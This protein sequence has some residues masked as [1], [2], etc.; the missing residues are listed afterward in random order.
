MPFLLGLDLSALS[1]SLALCAGLLL[2]VSG[3]GLDKPLNRSFVL[4]AG[5]ETGFV[6]C[7][8]LLRLALHFSV[9]NPQALLELVAMFFA[10]S[11]AAL[12]LF[13]IRFSGQEGW[14]PLGALAAA[15]VALLALLPA[16]L[17]GRLVEQPLLSPDGLLFYRITEPGF[18]TMLVP[19]ALL[20]AASLLSVSSVGRR[21]GWSIALSAGLQFGGF[22][23]G[24][25]I[26]PHLPVMALTNV[27]SVALLGWG[28]TRLQ[29]FNPL[30]DL[31]VSLRERAHRQE[32][33]AEI[34]RRTTTLLP[35]DELLNQAAALVRQSFDYLT[36]AVFL[37]EGADLV[38]K[39]STH[40]AARAHI[41]TFRLAVGRE[42]LCGWVASE[43]RPL[44]VGDVRRDSRY[45]GLLDST[46]TRS[47]LSVPIM[48][49]GRVIGVLDAQSRS[50]GAFGEPDMLTLQTIADQISSSIENARLYEETRRRAERLALVNRI[51]AASGAVLD[52]DDLLETVYR[53][54]TPIFE[55][56]AFFIAL[57]EETSGMLEFR[58]MVDEGRREPPVRE[59]VG[60]GLTAQVVESR[61]PVL[62]ND[63]AGEGQSLRLWGSGRVPA[64]W[65]GAPM[66]VGDRLVGVLSVQS[67]RA[68]RY[69][70][71]DLLLAATIAEQ[72]GVA[73]ENARLYQKVT[74]ELE[75]RLRT[76]KGLRESE[77][78]FRNLAEESPNMILIYADQRILYANR[79]C[80]VSMG[81][82]RET[83]YAPTFDLISL[84]APG[85]ET[86]AQRAARPEADARDAP[87]FEMVLLAREGRRVDALVTT[88][89][90]GF[91]GAP[92]TLTI[93]T[94]ITARKRAERLL[95]SLNAATLAMEQA[96]TPTEIFPS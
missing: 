71:E 4:F 94:D 13:C 41:G 75:V 81:Y 55:A 46:Q 12:L 30:H 20:L 84:V 17:R 80:E 23:A 83:L 96:L 45:V 58:L 14:W 11:A 36:V 43:G 64:S 54:V 31:T 56:D 44:V 42:G 47:E 93:V 92:A 8:V 35:L 38:L 95:Q 91:Q 50:R 7:S 39:A 26:Q 70:A 25:L 65:I 89:L 16:L 61:A 3:A 87:P 88:R 72:V 67:Y 86:L 66:L 18:L 90:I 9:G 49:S 53:E 48:R 74:R 15:T 82:S 33:I 68:G 52:L 32:L 2:A 6:A 37:V 21:R 59:P 40:P 60:P 79:Q 29:L 34:G 28:V 76:E 85:Y 51:S 77:E 69:D 24:G 27:G 62:I 73:V 78:K 19:T 5:A 10:L 22:V 63:P 57:H 1:V